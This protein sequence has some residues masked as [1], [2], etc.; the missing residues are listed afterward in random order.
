MNTGPELVDA[1]HT[2]DFFADGA[3]GFFNL[4]GNIKITLSSFR[5]DHGTAPG[6]VS[7]VVVGRLVM[8][9]PAA[10][11]LA[12]ELLAF[13]ERQKTADASQSSATIQ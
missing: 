10:E 1:P 12:K 6:P 8:P 7:R 11:A 3:A 4:N 5:V 2:P 13:I 9:L